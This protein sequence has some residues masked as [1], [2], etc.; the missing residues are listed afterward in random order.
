MT[1][2][3]I[4]SQL[5]LDHEKKVQ[6]DRWAAEQ[7]RGAQDDNAINALLA[8]VAWADSSEEACTE[9]VRLSSIIAQ[10]HLLIPEPKMRRLKVVLS[11]DKS[12][13]CPEVARLLE[14]LRAPATA[15]DGSNYSNTGTSQI[16][17]LQQ[18]QCPLWSDALSPREPTTN[19]EKFPF[20]P[21]HTLSLISL[22]PTS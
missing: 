22:H 2:E 6:I 13:W 20:S 14:S 17:T 18:E 9:L 11:A 21:L 15:A 5:T 1:G 16:V 10:N 7:S 8:K 19:M 4:S 3:A 12:V